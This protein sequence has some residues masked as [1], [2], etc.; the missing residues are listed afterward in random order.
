MS[1][2]RNRIEKVVTLREKELDK[3]LQQL[4]GTRAA[5]AKALSAEERKKEEL[6]QASEMRLKL[7]EE[8]AAIAAMSW[9]EANEWLANRRMQHEKARSE[10]VHAQIE[11]RKAQGAVQN[12]RTDLKKVELLSGRIQKQEQV[13]A[14]RVERRLED[15]LSALR[16]RRTESEK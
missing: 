1:P 5:E 2:R 6:E 4:A 3:R 9:I 8:G 7:A 11:T 16:F 13:Q 12:A 10:V 14:E 15:E